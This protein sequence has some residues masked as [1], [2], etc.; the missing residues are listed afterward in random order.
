MVI[1]SQKKLI[2][3]RITHV[4]KNAEINTSIISKMI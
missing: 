4:E 1:T 2:L 3:D